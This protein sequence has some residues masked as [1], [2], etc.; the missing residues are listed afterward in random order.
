MINQ[1]IW[2]LVY[3]IAIGLLVALAFYVV[4]AIPIT[5]PIGRFI[6]IVAVV[7]AVIGLVLLLLKITPAAA[8]RPAHQPY[9]TCE[10]HVP[11]YA[12]AGG[13]GPG[14]ALM[15]FFLPMMAAVAVPAAAAD[16]TALCAPLAVIGSRPP[17]VTPHRNGD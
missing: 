7:I 4:D 16:P 10:G 17:R 2:L 6:K 5:D 3:A 15:V 12:A 13:Y 8:Q 9:Y 1:F 14:Q 11:Y